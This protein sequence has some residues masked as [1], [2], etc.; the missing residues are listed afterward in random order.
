MNDQ[1]DEIKQNVDDD[2]IG[3]EQEKPRVSRAQIINLVLLGVAIL[4]VGGL[5]YYWSSSRIVVPNAFDTQVG[6]EAVK[7][8]TDTTE[9][10]QAIKELDGINLDDI[11]IEMKGLDE[12]VSS[13]E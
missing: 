6:T 9:E 13:F 3:E 10:E 1:N 2:V 5:L 8:L 11:N 4:A 7:S 12:T